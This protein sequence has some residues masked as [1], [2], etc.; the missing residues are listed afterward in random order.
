[1]VKFYSCIEDKKLKF[2]VTFAK[3][4]GKFVLCKHKLR[5]TLEFP[6]GHREPNEFI[7]DTAKRELKE[8]TGAKD[9]TL[10]PVCI[11]GVKEGDGEETYG[12]LC[13]ADITSFEPFDSEIEKIVITDTL[14]QNWT[15]PTIQPYL[16]KELERRN[17]L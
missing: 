11:Y 12:M 5:D 8:E 6:G 17:L 1:M 16:L 13:V 9:F 3:S 15:Y 10:E 2:A 4:D 14:T 7:V